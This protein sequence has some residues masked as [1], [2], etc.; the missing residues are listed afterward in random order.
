[1]RYD[2]HAQ[3]ITSVSAYHVLYDE[4]AT[5]VHVLPR[6][7]A[8]DVILRNYKCIASGHASLDLSTR[9]DAVSSHCK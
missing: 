1:M 2:L 5:W 6:I 8:E 4:A 9:K 7:Q 3:L